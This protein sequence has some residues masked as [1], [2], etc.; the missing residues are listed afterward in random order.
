MDPEVQA[1]RPAHDG[2]VTDAR[3]PGQ[4]GLDVIR[5][6]LLAVWQRQH[7]LLPPAQRQ[8]AV[9]RQL[10]E[11][12]GVVPALVIDGRRRRL[13][14]VPVAEESVGPADEEL[15]VVGDADLHAGDRL[16]HGPRAI[17]RGTSKADTRTHLRRAVP[18]EDLHAHLR[19]VR[20]EG[21]IE[22]RRTHADGV[23]PSTELR[24]HRPEDQSSHGSRKR[25]GHAM[26]PLEERPPAGLVDAAQ[27]GVVQQAQTLGDEEQ[28]R[29]LEVAEGSQQDRRLATDRVDNARPDEKRDD[30][31]DALL[32]EMRERQHRDE[33]LG[34]ADGEDRGHA[35]RARK[36]IP[37]ADHGALRVAGRAAREDDLGEVVGSDGRGR[38]RI[39]P[40]GLIGERLDPD[41]G[42]PQRSC[43]VRR[44]SAGQDEAGSGLRRDLRRELLGVA[45]VERDGHTARVGGGEEGDH[46]LRSIDR[47]DDDP[48]ARLEPGVRKDPGRSGHDRRQIAVAPDPRAEAGPDEQRRAV[49]IAR[50]AL[51]HEVD[52]RLHRDAPPRP[53][54]ACAAKPSSTPRASWRSGG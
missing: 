12:A 30:Q 19:P 6:D 26:K 41:D 37:M 31:A 1:E 32:E 46:P 21:R 43:A 53:S 4:H 45:D 48:I 28:H 42:Q 23:Q 52:Q 2:G 10:A 13:R 14:V 38:E 33:P 8:D 15:A 24:Q 17:Q 25:A 34:G 3:I 39:R 36:Q 16:A 11:V 5:V 29:R 18:L 9:G 20:G 50:G 22:R 44:L 54:A 51:G 47:P 49:V 35:L 27:D 40:A 7:V